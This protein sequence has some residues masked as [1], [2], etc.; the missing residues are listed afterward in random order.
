MAKA[1]KAAFFE[2]LTERYGSIQKLGNSKS[3]F[4]MK[5]SKIRIYVRYSKLHARNQMFYGVREKDLQQLEGH[6]SAICFLWDD[7]TEPLIIPF[8]DYEDIFQATTPASDGQYKIQIFLQE[9]GTELYI[10]RVGRFNVE[11]YFGWS[12]LENIM[13]STGSV[14]IPELSHS[15]I[16]TLLGSIGKSKGYDIWVPMNDRSRLDWSLTNRFD[17]SNLMRFEF[18]KA[19]DI[20]QEVDVIWNQRGSNKINALF[21]I[22]HSTPI[23][24]GLL[25]FNDIHLM[26][27]NLRPRFCV[28]ANDVRRSIFIKQLNRPTFVASGLNEICTFLEYINVYGW[29]NRILKTI[30]E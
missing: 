21:E 27:P 28:V 3:L 17:S 25:R 7:Q 26:L 29:Y 8:S 24:S 30:E 11:S 5:N 16:Q 4:E 6:S 19:K 1:I 9:D 23:Y 14:T 10:A 2:K 20:L 22:E 12:I 18:E 15:Q 13:D